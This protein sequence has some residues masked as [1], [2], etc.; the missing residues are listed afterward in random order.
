M[1]K[2]KQQEQQAPVETKAPVEQTVETTTE[3]A[4]VETKVEETVTETPV[5][6]PV[7]EEIAKAAAPFEPG[8]MEIKST[9]SR[10]YDLCVSQ[11]KNYSAAMA[12][13]VYHTPA[14]GARHQQELHDTYQLLFKLTPPEVR[15]AL[16]EFVKIF[17]E[18][19]HGCFS[20]GHLFRFAE[21]V[22]LSATAKRGMD[23][24]S[25]LLLTAAAVGKSEA[26]RLADLGSFTG[27]CPTE[28]ARQ[29]LVNYF[30]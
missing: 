8:A 26:G 4:P 2:N 27:W 12:V 29:L 14:V 18:N 19:E 17:K 30:R 23:H 15:D 5:Q 28:D 6:D 22:P 24:F 1:S 11:L 10:L 20:E 21:H 3:Q 9:H 25:H 16:D 13:G 7:P